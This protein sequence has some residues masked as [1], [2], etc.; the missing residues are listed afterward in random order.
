MG[1]LHP[2]QRGATSKLGGAIRH[3]VAIRCVLNAARATHAGWRRPDGW[4]RWVRITRGLARSRYAA[5]QAPVGIPQHPLYREFDTGPIGAA[6]VVGPAVLDTVLGRRPAVHPCSAV[7][8]VAAI[9]AFLSAAPA[10]ATLRRG[11]DV[12]VAPV[13]VTSRTFA[14]SHQPRL[15]IGLYGIARDT[16]HLRIHDP[17]VRVRV[18]DLPAVLSRQAK[19]VAVGIGVT[20]RLAHSSVATKPRRAVR[21]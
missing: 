4:S 14:A 11:G 16:A 9:V 19:H 2:G 3:T 12:P 1:E 21:D 18:D 15:R 13:Q 7:V 20:V 8:G 10:R 5:A 17:L 6:V